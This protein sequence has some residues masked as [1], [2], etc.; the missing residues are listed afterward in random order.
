MHLKIKVQFYEYIM[1]V[2]IITVVYNNANT[3]RSAINSVL[4]QSYNEIEYIIIDGAS[5]DKTLDII[6]EYRDKI[7]VIVSEKD[8][9]IYDAMNKGILQAT[10][11]IIGILNSDDLYENNKIIELIADE[12]I[13]DKKLEILYGDLVYVAI[14][15]IAKIVRK[16]TSCDYDLTFFE[17]GEVPPHPSL[18]LK[19]NVYNIAGLFNLEY[20]LASDYEFMLRVFKKN[21]FKIKYINKIL[22]KM[23]LG[24]ATNKNY[25]NIYLGN[26]EIHKAWNKNGLKIPLFFTPRRIYK[27]FI[28]F[29]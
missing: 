26:V 17:R 10:G 21:T 24:G 3:I 15:D 7:S 27:R 18:F 28:Q 19:K 6:N 11:D 12:F 5:T 8:K 14:N 4:N 16:W 2:S 1:K 20:K 29:L 13:K 25:K 23:R 9:G 22:V